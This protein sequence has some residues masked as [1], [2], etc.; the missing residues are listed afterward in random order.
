M[1]DIIKEKKLM[2]AFFDNL[3]RKPDMTTLGEEDTMHTLQNGASGETFVSTK[4]NKEKQ[5]ELKKMALNVGSTFELISTETEEGE[6]FFN[7]GGIGSILR[8][9]I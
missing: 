5:K 1:E 4:I 2:E 7:L 8:F 9:K 6:Q 3:G